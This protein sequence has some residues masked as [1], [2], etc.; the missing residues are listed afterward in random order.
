MEMLE[1]IY[2]NSRKQQLKF[3]GDLGRYI[4]L[5]CARIVTAL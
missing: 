2:M 1:G 3:H 5:L 4:A